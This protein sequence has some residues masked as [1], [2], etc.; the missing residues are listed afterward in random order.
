M[1]L[2][3]DMTTCIPGGRSAVTPV[4]NPTVP[5]ADID[6]NSTLSRLKADTVSIAIVVIRTRPTESSAMVRA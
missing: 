1:N 3:N 5:T 2:S 6:S 4:D